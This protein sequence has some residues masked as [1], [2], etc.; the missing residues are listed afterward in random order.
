MDISITISI[1][2]R[3][4]IVTVEVLKDPI[5]IM[6]ATERILMRIDTIIEADMTDP[7]GEMN[8]IEVDTPQR[9]KLILKNLLTRAAL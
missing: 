1:I 7:L 9:D 5:I 4:M 6:T 3:G 8:M 2:I